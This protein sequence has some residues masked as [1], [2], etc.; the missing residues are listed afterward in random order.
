MKKPKNS[1]LPAVDAIP[2]KS[3]PLAPRGSLTCTVDMTALRSM[4]M[5][6][7]RS[8]RDVLHQAGGLLTAFNNQP[9]FQGEDDHSLN[10]A[11]DVIDSILNFLF[12]YEEAVINVA[13]AAKP[14]ST[15]EAIWQHWTLLSFSADMADSLNNFAV[16][17]AEA[18]RDVAKIKFH[19]DHAVH[20]RGAA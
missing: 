11:G 5:F 14:T 13:K 3:D 12:E 19:E 10:T 8:L 15:R 9:R 1:T 7:L 17:A 18:A 2:A 20:S 6:E 16:A 4:T